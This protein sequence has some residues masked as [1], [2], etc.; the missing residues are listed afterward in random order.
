VQMILAAHEGMK[1][2]C[3]FVENPLIFC[4]VVCIC[5]IELLQNLR[6]HLIS[7]IF[8]RTGVRKIE[9]IEGHKCGEGHIVVVGSDVDIEEQNRILNRRTQ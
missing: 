6:L 4:D 9:L 5:C 8:T 3:S 7:D 2:R 1:S